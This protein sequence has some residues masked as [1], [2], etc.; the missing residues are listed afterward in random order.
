MIKNVLGRVLERRGRKPRRE[1][2]EMPTLEQVE[3]GHIERVLGETD[4]NITHAAE[5]LGLD[6]RTL[7][8]K[9]EK[10]AQQQAAGK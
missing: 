2:A 8:R 4:G 9:L 6:R 1:I 5:L 3:I 7:Y 10:Y